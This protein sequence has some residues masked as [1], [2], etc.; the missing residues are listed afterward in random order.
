[1]CPSLKEFCGFLYLSLDGSVQRFFTSPL[2]QL[3]SSATPPFSLWLSSTM[4]SLYLCGSL[5]TMNH[6]ASLS[7]ALLDDEKLL[8]LS[9]WLSSAKNHST[10]LS[11]K[12]CTEDSNFAEDTPAE[13][14][15]RRKWTPIDDVVLNSLWLNTSKDPVPTLRQ[16]QRL[17]AVNLESQ[18][19]QVLWSCEAATRE[20]SSGQNKNDVLKL[21]HEIFFNNHRKKF[22]F[23]HAW[24]ELRNDQKWCDLSASK[25]DGSAKRRKFEDGAQS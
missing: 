24:K 17:Q 8:S 12:L 20:K 16:I 2:S 19:T 9:R 7:V 1:M 23:E 25:T 14:R 10:S 13:R 22:N 5:S 11:V 15:E 21:A 18:V 3:L 6:S 4:K